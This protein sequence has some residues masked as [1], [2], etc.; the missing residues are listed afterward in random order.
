MMLMEPRNIGEVLGGYRILGRPVT[1][2]LELSD[3]VVALITAVV[4]RVA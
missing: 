2:L 3:A 4:M 1:S